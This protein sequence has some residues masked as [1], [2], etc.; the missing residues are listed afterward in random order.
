MASVTV[1]RT[2]D[3]PPERVREAMSDVETFMRAAGFA[4]V[5]LDGDRL[6]IANT[7][8]LFLEIELDLELVERRDAVLAYEQREGIFREMRT[9]YRIEPTDGGTTVT[10][11]TEFEV[12]VALAGPL[13]DASVVTRQRRAELRK[14]FD[15]LEGLAD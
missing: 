9:V 10:A 3:T 1:T 11:T 12:D 15:Y 6:H 14:Q 4:E 13:L 5:D 2:V 7:A 8:G